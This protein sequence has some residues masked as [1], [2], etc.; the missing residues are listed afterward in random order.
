M[1][2][3]LRALWG[4]WHDWGKWQMFNGETQAFWEKEAQTVTL[5]CRCCSKCGKTQVTHLWK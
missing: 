5:Q 4:C 2:G 3:F 1:L